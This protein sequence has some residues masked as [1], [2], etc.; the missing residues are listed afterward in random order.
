M[1]EDHSKTLRKWIKRKALWSQWMNCA[2]N[3]P[4][5]RKLCRRR[6][7]KSPVCPSFKQSLERQYS[8]EKKK[9]QAV[10]NNSF[11][12]GEAVTQDGTRWIRQ[13]Y[14]LQGDLKGPEEGWSWVSSRGTR[15]L[16]GKGKE[17]PH[18]AGWVIHKFRWRESPIEAGQQRWRMQPLD[19]GCLT[20][21]LNSPT[22]FCQ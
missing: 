1:N 20:R 2:N 12:K 13:L 9:K 22:L 14:W 15:N 16:R 17:A 21:N 6:W 3:V 4:W 18:W 11:L 8:H 10:S 19:P 5:R 7:V